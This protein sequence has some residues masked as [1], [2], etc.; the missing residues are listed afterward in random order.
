MDR[1]T[2]NNGAVMKGETT[3]TILASVCLALLV[4]DLAMR[5]HV[6]RTVEQHGHWLVTMAAEIQT[7]RQLPDASEK[8]TVG[9]QLHSLD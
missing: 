8:Q 7:L 2:T 5:W 4:C 6:A 3:A 9:F 1:E